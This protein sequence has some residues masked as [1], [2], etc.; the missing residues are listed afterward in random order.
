I[1]LNSEDAWVFFREVVPTAVVSNLLSRFRVNGA[2]A[3]ADSNVRVVQHVS[4]AVVIPHP[5]DYRPLE[6]FAGRH[7]TGAS[8]KLGPHTAY[9][10]AALGSFAGNIRSFRLKRGYTATFARNE[11]GTGFSRNYVAQD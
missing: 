10:T 7:L 8:A 1:H 6:V 3:V 4:G 5:A 11:N 2:V 9:G